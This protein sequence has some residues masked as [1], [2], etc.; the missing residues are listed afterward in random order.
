MINAK[1]FSDTL[2][3]HPTSPPVSL[4]FQF[5]FQIMMCYI[6]EIKR[7]L[8]IYSKQRNNM[9]WRSPSASNLSSRL[10]HMSIDEDPDSL[11]PL[12]LDLSIQDFAHHSRPRSWSPTDGA[13]EL[14]YKA[15]HLGNIYCKIICFKRH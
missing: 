13:G 7:V 8:F 2:P 4:P 11:A 3:P 12:D 9:L 15:R 5:N 14:L 1:T 10:S 6:L